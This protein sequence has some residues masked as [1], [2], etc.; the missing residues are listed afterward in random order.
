MSCGRGAALIGAAPLLLILWTMLAPGHAAEPAR[1]I[2][3]E[4]LRPFFTAL[5][6]LD[7][8]RSRAPVRIMQIG[9]SHTASD[10][11]SGRMRERLQ[12]RFGAAGRGWL[13]AGVPYKYFQPRLVT[14]SETGWRHLRASDTDDKPPLGLDAVVARATEADAR[15]T[16]SSNDADGFDRVAVEFVARPDGQPLTIRAD[17]NPPARIVTAAPKIGVRRSEV[18]LPKPAHQLDLV[19][20]GPPGTEVLGWAVER[21]RSGV[22]YENHGSVG[23]TVRLLERLDPAT[24]SFELA[25]RRPALLVIAFGTNEGFRDGLDPADYAARFRA[26]VGSLARRARGGAVLVLGPPDGN[27]RPGECAGNAGCS[28]GPSTQGDNCAW[29]V[30][31][32]L[33]EVRAAQRRLALRQGWAFWD[34]SA[35]MG[36]ACS[37]HQGLGEDPP[38]AMPDH[39]HLSKAGYVRTADRLFTDLMRAYDEWKR[40]P[41]RR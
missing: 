4:K 18:L 35:A 9:D 10:S 2:G 29:T 41:R 6:A 14:V 11:F 38:L 39:V 40:A 32:K 27:R 36:G 13:P 22:I 33:A 20:S 37:M 23:G 24:V 28:V 25:D 19:A 16:L 8:R 15:M 31:P 21:R 1:L 5:A 7:Q 30:P 34:W 17:Q 26:A 3:A 12:D